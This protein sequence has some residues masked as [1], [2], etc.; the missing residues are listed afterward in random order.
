MKLKAEIKIKYGSNDIAKQILR[1]INPE[2]FVSKELKIRSSVLNDELITEIVT[3]KTVGTLKNT[4]D[5]L[6]MAIQLAEKI[7]K[8]EN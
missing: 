1:S 2:N 3:T 6:L 5:D 8:K 4:I 7:L